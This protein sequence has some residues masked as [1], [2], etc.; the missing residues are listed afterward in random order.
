MLLTA[1]SQPEGT[2]LLRPPSTHAQLA[3][4]LEALLASASALPAHE[5][6]FFIV[7]RLFNQVSLLTVMRQGPQLAV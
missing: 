2:L 6:E 4:V 5:L 7:R 1:G 3:L